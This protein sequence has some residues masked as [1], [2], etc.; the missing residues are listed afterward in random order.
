MRKQL[1]KTQLEEWEEVLPSPP[2][3]SLPD[4]LTCP[5]AWTLSAPSEYN[6]T[7]FLFKSLFSSYK[8]FCKGLILGTLRCKVCGCFPYQCMRP[9]DISFIDS[10]LL[11]T[12]LLPFFL[13]NHPF[14]ANHPLD[15][16]RCCEW[17]KSVHISC[18]TASS[19]G[20]CQEC[21]CLDLRCQ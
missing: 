16:W 14:N 4:S 7:D 8:C 18:K 20:E 12:C 10:C 9:H 1:R 5:A 11:R 17:R 19:H 3:L 6:G 15:V 2:M 21:V 13:R